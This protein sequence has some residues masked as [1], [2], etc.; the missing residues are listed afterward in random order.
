MNTRKNLLCTLRIRKDVRLPLSTSDHP[1][2]QSRLTMQQNNT[3]AIAKIK[4]SLKNKIMYC[5]PRWAILLN[6]FF[7]IRRGL[8]KS[9]KYFAPHLTGHLLD[10]GA[11][12]APYRSLFANTSGYTTV[13]VEESGH[14]KG[15]KVADYYYDGKTLPFKDG[16]FDSILASEVFEHVF[17]LDEILQELNRVLA[18]GGKMLVTVP[19]VWDEHEAPYDFARYSTFGLADLLERNGFEVVRHCKTTSYLETVAQM[20]AAY[21]VQRKIIYNNSVL[22][23]IAT[24][25]LAFPI[26]AMGHLLAAVLPKDDR[27]YHNNVFLVRKKGA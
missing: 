25:V 5:P 2:A 15:V 1:Q 10:F 21:L 23:I 11:G 7:T 3:L 18:E 12:R 16:A 24:I 8:Y 27:F 19:F 14:P 6:P 26:N 17:N 20:L 4:I 13:D 9:L 22:R